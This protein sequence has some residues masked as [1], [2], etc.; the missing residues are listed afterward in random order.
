MFGFPSVVSNKAS[1]MHAMDFV[2][3]NPGDAWRMKELLV[4]L[5]DQRFTLVLKASSA[6]VPV[7]EQ[8][9][10][11]YEAVDDPAAD[12]YRFGMTT[13]EVDALIKELK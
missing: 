7:E 10:Q 1:L 6:Y 13:G 11:D 2:R 9:P 4:R 3:A 5:R 12:L 8:T